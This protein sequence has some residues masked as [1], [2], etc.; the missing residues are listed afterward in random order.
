MA[1]GHRRGRSRSVSSDHLIDED[2]S[3]PSSSKIRRTVALLIFIVIGI[4]QLASQQRLSESSREHHLRGLSIRTRSQSKPRAPTKSWSDFFFGR[5]P[6]PKPLSAEDFQLSKCACQPGDPRD[7]GKP[8]DSLGECHY[9][10]SPHNFC[11]TGKHYCRGKYTKCRDGDRPLRT[12]HRLPTFE[13]NFEDVVEAPPGVRAADLQLLSE[14]LEWRQDAKCGPG[15]PS[16]QYVISACDPRGDTPCCSQEGICGKSMRHCLSQLGGHDYRIA[17]QGRQWKQASEDLAQTGALVAAHDESLKVEPHHHYDL[18]AAPVHKKHGGWESGKS[19]EPVPQY[20]IKF[21]T[22]I[23]HGGRKVS[24]MGIE[25]RQDGKCGKHNPT[26]NRAAAGCNP[27]S[28]TPCCI[29]GKCVADCD[30]GVGV[31]FRSVTHAAL[32][33]FKLQRNFVWHGRWN[34]VLVW[35]CIISLFKWLQVAPQTL[36]FSLV[37]T[38]VLWSMS[39][40][41]ARGHRKS[42]C[43]LQNRGEFAP[44]QGLAN[45]SI[46]YSLRLNGRII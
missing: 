27:D 4:W 17:Y 10:C 45:I 2:V 41:V 46:V 16:K 23:L 1:R 15:F 39:K 11:G 13:G 9:C 37:P 40:Y 19:D 38:Q 20:G 36:T 14:K 31:D 29:S 5:N 44:P 26:R 42:L 34:V 7:G 25:W 35:F 18:H 24:H 21:S 30:Q 3:A 8:V 33:P 6:L 32:R 28:H 43:C 12:K 22:L